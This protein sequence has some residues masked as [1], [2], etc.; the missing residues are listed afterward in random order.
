MQ[1]KAKA[2][3]SLLAKNTLLPSNGGIGSMVKI[4]SQRLR[5]IVLPIRVVVAIGVI[6]GITTPPYAI[7]ASNAA[8]TTLDKGPIADI[9]PK[10]Q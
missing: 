8:R 1:P 3:N 9:M 5:L 10:D 4:A 7:T 6:G 2:Y